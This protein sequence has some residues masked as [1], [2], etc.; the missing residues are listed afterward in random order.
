MEGFTAL[1]NDYEEKNMINCIKVAR[2]APSI[3]HMFFADDYYIFCKASMERANCVLQYLTYLR[4]LQVN[5]LMWISPQYF[6]A[7]IPAIL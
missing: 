4:E 5:R 6:L 3:S 1:I 7:V 2:S